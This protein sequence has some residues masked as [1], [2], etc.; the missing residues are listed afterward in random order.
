MRFWWKSGGLGLP[1]CFQWWRPRFKLSTYGVGHRPGRR[2]LLF[3][4]TI[5]EVRSGCRHGGGRRGARLCKH[6]VLDMLW[7]GRPILPWIKD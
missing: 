2:E 4:P 5:N 1:A 6:G 3:H 7:R